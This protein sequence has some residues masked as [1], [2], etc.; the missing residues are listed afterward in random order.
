[1]IKSISPVLPVSA[2]ER[3]VAWYIDSAG[4]EVV[5]ADKMY[6]V[7]K[8]ASICLHLQWHANTDEDPLNAGSVV[9]IFVENIQPIYNEFVQ[10]KTIEVDALR[11]NTPW[12]THEFGFYDP[13]KNAIFIVE[14]F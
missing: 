14:D 12:L 1:M 4:F 2:I 5:F 3:S 13:D 7:L 8:R 6:A 10:R 11:L 9:R